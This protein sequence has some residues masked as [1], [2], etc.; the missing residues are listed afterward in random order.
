MMQ[1]LAA[2]C[3]YLVASQGRPANWVVFLSLMAGGAFFAAAGS[4]LNQIVERRSDQ[5]MSR[6]KDRPLASGR[7]SP[8][9][10]WIWG[11][12]L[13]TGGLLFF[14]L[15]VNPL[16]AAI[17]ACGV[18]YYVIVY[19]IWL[20]PRSTLNIVVG[21][22]AGAVA[23]L[24]GWAAVAGTVP[25]SAWL[26]FLLI[27]LWTPPHFWAIASLR[28]DDYRAAGFPMLPVVAGDAEAARQMLIYA[29]LVL[30]VG[31]VFAQTSTSLS[32]ASTLAALAVGSYFTWKV[33]RLNTVL[34]SSPQ[35]KISAFRKVFG[36]SI[37]YLWICMLVFSVD[38]L[39]K[40][41][42]I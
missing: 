22:A 17:S 10:G 34:K 40:G 18:L 2:L 13:F 24:A 41:M 32:P 35:E 5:L 12:F 37:V 8:L 3:G 7:M 20:K 21:G 39:V 42:V 33:V 28:A 4:T 38:A 27:V 15:G 23:P 36:A 14:L 31:V 9:L 1:V 30:V 19:T 16:A 6:T 26:F 11:T 25:L 29:V